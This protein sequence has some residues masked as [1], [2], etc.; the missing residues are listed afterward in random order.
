MAHGMWHA[1][2]RQDI[3]ATLEQARLVRRFPRYEDKML[4]E[5]YAMF[6]G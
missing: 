4:S 3:R 2:G 5:R 6:V 1:G